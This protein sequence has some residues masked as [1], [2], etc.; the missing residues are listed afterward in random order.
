MQIKTEEFAELAKREV[1]KSRAY[2]SLKNAPN[3]LYT[4]RMVGMKTL[5]DVAAYQAYGAAIRAEALNRLPELLEEFEK[6]AVANGAKVVWS[7]NAKEAD[8]Y[9]VNLA[10]ER[11]AKFVIKGKSMVTE[12][13]GLNDTLNDQGIVPWETDLGEFIAQQMQRPPF[14][15]VAPA[16]NLTCEEICEVFMKQ[17]D[18]KE[19]TLDP[20]ALGLA[21]RLFLREKFHRASF[22]V[23]GVNVAVAETGTTINLENEGNIRFTKSSPR[24]L[25]L[26]MSIEKV[27]PTMKDAMHIVRLLSRNCTG[28]RLPAYV[29]MDS[30]PKRTGEIDGPD[31]MIIVIVDNGRSKLYQDTR[32]REALRC[33]RCAA[34]L[35]T[36]PV[37]RQIG[38]YS[39]GWVY[40]G[41]MGQV[42][43]PLLLGLD[44]TQHLYRATTL[45]GACKSVCPAGIDHPKLFLYYR[46]MDVSGA[47]YFKGKKRPSGEGRFF[48]AWSMALTH[49][50]LWNLGVRLARNVI[51]KFAADGVISKLPGGTF[52]GWFEK[53]DLPAIAKKT[54]R[55]RWKETK[56]GN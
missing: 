17:V 25:V 18:M 23:A 7:R 53:R 40:S 30:G 10:K 34:C 41:P 8:E 33:I 31:E 38:G 4:K 16:I 47:P 54:F 35:N 26:V 55:E 45:C 48:K 14:H 43:M 56:G 22:G 37:Y 42:L 51:N 39:Y 9:I 20:V 5:P 19:R 6:N 28:Q 12:E 44:R 13:I 50:W 29:S 24:T 3:M 21:A 32:A 27:V 11:G 36:C 46:S 1:A 2:P 52:A 15:I 49:A